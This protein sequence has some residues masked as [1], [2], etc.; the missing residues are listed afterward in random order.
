MKSLDSRDHSKKQGP[1]LLGFLLAHHWSDQ[2]DR[3]YQIGP[4]QKPIWLCARCLGVYP[5][6][7]GILV[8]QFFYALS[9][10]WW[11]YIALFVLPIPAL[12]D[13]AL[14]RLGIF[15]GSN[16]SR[17][18]TGAILG[19]S[20]GRMVYIHMIDPINKLVIIQWIVICGYWL[21]VEI[22]VRLLVHKDHGS[23]QGTN[24]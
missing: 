7:V 18:I 17:T 13:W 2:L 4:K 8:V 10:G 3:C 15:A 23:N 19:L 6:L 1:G 9:I 5:V 11:D 14:S 20:L 16:L 21:L 12:I 22:L 24:S